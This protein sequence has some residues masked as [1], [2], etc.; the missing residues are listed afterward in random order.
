MEDPADGVVEGLGGR[1]S[2]VTTLVG[3]DPEAGSEQALE[4]GVESPQ[5]SGRGWP[6]G[7]A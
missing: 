2:L 5:S 7:S 6:H 1:E 3:N 4:D